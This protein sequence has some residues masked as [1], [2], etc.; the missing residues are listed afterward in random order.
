METNELKFK[1]FLVTTITLSP[2]QYMLELSP[3]KERIVIEHGVGI[4]LDYGIGT[5]TLK[6]TFN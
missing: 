3:S 2:R 6:T 4:F 1:T 5:E